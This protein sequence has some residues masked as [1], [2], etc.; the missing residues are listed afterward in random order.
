MK[1][2]VVAAFCTCSGDVMA[3]NAETKFEWMRRFIAI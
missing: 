2:I 3:L 1:A